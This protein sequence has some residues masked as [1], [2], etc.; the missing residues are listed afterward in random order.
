[1]VQNILFTFAYTY[2]KLKRYSLK[3]FQI[4]TVQL[5]QLSTFLTC[6]SVL[7]P[8]NPCSCFCRAINDFASCFLLCHIKSHWRSK[9]LGLHRRSTSTSTSVVFQSS[10]TDFPSVNYLSSRIKLRSNPVHVFLTFKVVPAQHLVNI[11]Q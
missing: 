10:S 11:I 9:Y 3:L 2:A 5:R 8:V 6:I 7:K 1:M 4:Y